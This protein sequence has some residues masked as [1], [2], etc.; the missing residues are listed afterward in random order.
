[1]ISWR[2]LLR[3]QAR[4]H[5]LERLDSRLPL[6]LLAVDEEGRGRVDAE[7]LGRGEAAS[8]NLVLDRLVAEAGVELLLA[9]PGE[10]NELFQSG[11]PILGDH[12]FFLRLEQRLDQREEALGRDAA[13]QHLGPQRRLVEREIA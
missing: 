13:R 9:D 1:M 6:I 12:P 2:S 11:A 3:S 7:L 5:Q 8:R 4:Q 10:T